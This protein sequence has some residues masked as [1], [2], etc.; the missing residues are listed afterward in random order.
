V[1]DLG[2]RHACRNDLL[3]LV[4][5]RRREDEEAVRALLAFAHGSPE[6]A[7]SAAAR[8]AAREW[9]LVGWEDEGELVACAGMERTSESEIRIRSVASLRSRRSTRR[10]AVRAFGALS[11][12]RHSR[13]RL[14]QSE[15]SP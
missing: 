13:W 9:I 8:Y 12:S 1:S 7:E 15:L 2:S 5:L 4:D 6:S 10:T 3:G 11:R 14:P